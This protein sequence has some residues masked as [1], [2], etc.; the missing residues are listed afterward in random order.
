[1][2]VVFRA[3]DPRIGRQVAIKLL[4]VPDESLRER[5]VQEAQSVGNLTHRNI[6]TVF[7]FGEHEGHSYIVMEFIEGVT[8]ADQIQDR[9]VMTLGRKLEII[10]ELAA[11]LDYA[12]NKGIVHRDIKP[13]N[14]MAW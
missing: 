9:E 5:F 7:D 2:G 10:E 3:R 14:V 8:L 1:M 4:S 6:V 13:A 11:G 12:H